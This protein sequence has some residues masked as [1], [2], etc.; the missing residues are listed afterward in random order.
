M[1]FLFCLGDMHIVPNL[2]GEQVKSEMSREFTRSNSGGG[3]NTSI[4]NSGLS[5]LIK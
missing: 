3:P 2:S 5:L 1:S 4:H